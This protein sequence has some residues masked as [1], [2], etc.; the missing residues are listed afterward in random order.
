MA[1]SQ[2]SRIGVFTATA[3]IAMAAVGG[4]CLVDLPWIKCCVASGVQ[5]W[6]VC[7]P[8]CQFERTIDPSIPQTAFANPGQAGKDDAS[9]NVYDCKYIKQRCYNGVTCVPDEEETTVIC[10]ASQVKSTAANCTG[11]NPQ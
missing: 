4:V 5:M 11:Q 2:V 10:Y 7:S 3:S 1:R 9:M 8:A 6:A